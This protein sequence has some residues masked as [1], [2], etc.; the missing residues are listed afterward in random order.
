MSRFS[1]FPCG[2]PVF[3]VPFVEK[4]MCFP[5][6]CLCFFVKDQLVVFTWVDFG[7]FSVLFCLSICLIFSKYTVLTTI[8]L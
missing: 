2:C 6:N 4:I 1:F 7:G 8:A 5:L 3:S